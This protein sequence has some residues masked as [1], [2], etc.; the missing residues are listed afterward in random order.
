MYKNKVVWITGASSGIGEALAVAFSEQGAILVLSARRLEE[1]ERVKRRTHN[2]DSVLL[3]PVDLTD[4]SSFEEKTSIVI[5]KLG[6]IDVLI[7]NGGISHRSLALETPLEIVRKVFEINFFSYV[8]LTRAVLPYFLQQ[9]SGQIGVV[10]SIAGKIGAKKRSA[11][12]ASKHALLG[13][14]NTLRAEVHQHNIKITVF[15]PG[16]VQT[17]ISYHA[18]LADGSELNKLDPN[19]ANGIPA[20]LFAKKAL[21]GLARNKA[22]VFNGGKDNFT[23]YLFRFFPSLLPGVLRRKN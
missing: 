16:Y 1:L 9:N 22:E 4:I 14:F 13:Y 15:C 8:A 20:E 3:L 18:L 6:R 5:A 23:I 7:H 17:N 21:R 19:I 2:P 10:S 11:Y 12:A